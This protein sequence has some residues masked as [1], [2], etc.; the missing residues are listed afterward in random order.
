MNGSTDLKGVQSMAAKHVGFG[1]W[2]VPG[3]Q[4]SPRFH[5]NDGVLHLFSHVHSLGAGLFSTLPMG[6]ERERKDM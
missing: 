5:L 3:C 2:S 1:V 4:I 6:M